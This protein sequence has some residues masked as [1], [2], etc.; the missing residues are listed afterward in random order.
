MK[1]ISGDLRDRIVRVRASGDSAAAVSERFGVSK[2]SVE[3]YW[4]QYQL[5]GHTRAK[6]RG[7]YK[8]SR[9]CPYDERLR[10]WIAAQP[11][12]TLS[13]LKERCRKELGVRIGIN[14]LWQRLD[15]LGLS[16][17]KNAARKRTVPA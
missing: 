11:D 7:G 4:R 17:K 15:K 8:R 3:R 13:E 2:R 10:E 14:A 5:V 6:A 1:S 16:Y 9:L 12:L